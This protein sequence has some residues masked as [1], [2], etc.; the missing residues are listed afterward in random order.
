[1]IDKAALLAPRLAEQDVPV[2]DLGTVRIRALSRAE[3]ADI[4]AQELESAALEAQ[5]LATALVEPAMTVP[6]VAAWQAA[7][8]GGE[9][10]PI[11]KA[12]LALSG[13]AVTSEKEVVQQF[14]GES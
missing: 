11:V 14:P 3:V 6:E 9:F 5:M 10:E 7:A 8:A 1:M 2:G 4:Q 12:V 13:M